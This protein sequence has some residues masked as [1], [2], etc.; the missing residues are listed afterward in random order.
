M[1]T[2]SQNYM[3]LKGGTNSSNSTIYTSD[4]SNTQ[5]AIKIGDTIKI[6]GTANN[7][8]VFTV[9][10]ITTDGTALGSNGDV[11]YSLKG[12]AIANESSN[13]DRNLEIEVVRAP[14][15][16][17][18]ALGDVD[19]TGNIDVWSNNNT[20]DYVGTSPGSADGWTISAISPTLDGDDAKY[21]YH[22]IDEALRVCNI[23]EQNTSIIK[24][25]GYIQ[26]Q[27]FSHKYGLTFSG[28]QE[29]PNTL[30]PPKIATDVTF[31]YVNS[32]AVGA[33]GGTNPTLG[34]DPHANDE[35]TNYY[36]ESRG[37]A[38]AKKTST[39]DLRIKADNGNMADMLSDTQKAFLLDVLNDNDSLFDFGGN[40]SDGDG[41]ME[42]VVSKGFICTNSGFVVNS[43]AGRLT[44]STSNKGTAYLR[45][46]TEI[47]KKYQVGFDLLSSSNANGSVSLSASTTYGSA[48]SGAISSSGVENCTLTSSFTATATTSYLHLRVES[49]TNTE[50]ADFDNLTIR[51]IDQFVF[52][53]TNPT[54]VLDQCTVGE[55]ITIDEALG[56]FPKEFLFCT[57]ISGGAGGP[58]SYSRAYGGKL[59]GTAPDVYAQDD[60]PIIERGLGFNIGVTDGTATGSWEAGT[61]E[62]YQTFVYENHQESLPLQ[63]GDGDDGSNLAAGTHESSGNLALR[64]SVYADV[65]YS[66]RVVGGRIYTRLSGTD[67]EL[68]LLVDIDIV[69]GVRTTIDGDH[70][71]WQ[72]ETGKGYYVVGDAS[73]N[74]SRPNIDTYNTINGYSPEAHFNA[75]GGRNES[76]K[77]SVVA[78]RRAFIANVKLKGANI[79]LQKYGDRIMYS[80]INKF[81]TFLPHNFID[82]SKG[83]YGEYTALESFADRLL[84][85]KHNLV[86]V[87]NIASP[88]VANWYLEDTIRYYGVNHQFSVAKTNNGI[89]WVSD[90]GCY[91][92]DGQSVRNLID[93]K[94]AVS[95]AS[96]TGTSVTWQDWYRGTAFLKDVMLGYDAMSNSLVML[97]SPSD[98]TNNSNTGWIYDFDTRGWVYHDAIFTN[99]K[100]Y[101]NFTT[102][103][104]NNL[105]VGQEGSSS[106]IEFK[107]FLPVSKT[108]TGQEFV[109][110]DIDF[111]EPG[112]VKKI[113]KVIVTYKSDGAETTPFSYAV[114]GKQNFSGDGG[115]TFTGN[116]VDTSNKW[117]VVTL[118]PSS[119][120]SC[121]SIQIKFDA[122]S[123]GIFEIND[124]SIQYRVLGV[125]EVT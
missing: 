114:D 6:T 29:H 81:D 69:K 100:S 21:I 115:G 14:G 77:C 123:T 103:W 20:T 117:D 11:Y 23:N 58:M 74:S 101:T 27:Q 1:A 52:E 95:Q 24:W 61:Y 124:M 73:G 57:R 67:N 31:C 78:N 13:T 105:T 108:A 48:T 22:F 4:D 59:T 99:D 109:T 90:D 89:A 97:R 98:G 72:Y 8:G 33:S 55:V 26:R 41:N 54:D 34:D 56:T 80:E 60:T 9:T 104:N 113:Y 19:N 96:Y 118:T 18:V 36:S 30:A 5:N 39:S 106:D 76:Y 71:P 116:L 38:R 25:Y 119:I 3:L 68:I 40:T 7:N 92:Y 88:S 120:I 42:D 125:K 85:F 122:P 37:V 12:A 15:D 47:G 91:L 107:K 83:D 87:I 110:R 17:L 86:H 2:P 84:A 35:A 111:N 79:E 65:A 51:K 50:Y 49:N 82:V 44:N 53:D 63:M 70:V 16:K 121:Q 46:I 66:G 102:D 32:P 112:L 94:L 64:V 75:L 28:W 93:R 62:F 43:G 45:F 10:D